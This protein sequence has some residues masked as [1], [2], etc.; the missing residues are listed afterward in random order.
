M[1]L[2][3]TGAM[4]VTCD[5]ARRVLD[6]ASVAISGERIAAVGDAAG[7]EREFPRHPRMDGRGLAVLPGLVNAHTHT[8]L[9]ALRG[10]VEDFDGDIIYRYMSPVSYTMSDH[11]RGVMA[12]LGCLEAIRSGATTLVEPF[13]HLP[14]FAGAMADTGLRLWLSES[15]ADIDT[16]KIRFG[17][18]SIDEAFGRVFLER[19]EALVEAWHGARDGRV[20]CQI[21]AHAPDNCS[22][23]MLHRLSEMARRHGLTRTCHLAQSPG[24]LAAVKAAHGLT[25]AAYLD[26]EGFL[27]PDLTCAHWTFC[28]PDDIA[29]LAAR[30]V[31]MAHTPANSSR[32]GPHGVLAG[33]IQDAGINIALGTDNMTEDMFQAMKIGMI[34]HRGGLGRARPGGVDP[35]PQAVLDMATR[36]GA[37]TL[38]A[39]AEIGSIEPGKKADLT[40]IDLDQ[41]AMRPLLRPVSN[42]VHYGHPGIVHSVMVDGS[43]VMRERKVLTIDEPALLAE[44]QAVTERVWRRML[45]D[46]PDL[47]PPPDTEARLGTRG[48]A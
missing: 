34:L 7:L 20:K 41:P 45:A 28:T 39:E 35:Q 22:P 6:N 36:N 44:A 30:G 18:Y 12:A 8:V 48:A 24:E 31:N 4:V 38:G 10:T 26:R 47:T 23:A 27:G 11:E 46:N 9:T 32:K 15:C 13:R 37:R 14:S 43:F 3:I 2:L 25:P 42:I 40:M 21:A 5:D 29:L 16:R 1:D 19:T 17:D 33:L